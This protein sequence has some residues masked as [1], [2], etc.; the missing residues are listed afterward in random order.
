MMDEN[1]LLHRRRAL[2][3][4]E[5]MKDAGKSWELYVFSS[6]NAIRKYAMEELVELGISWVWMGLESPQSGYAKLD[7]AD[8]L[9]LVRELR[10][11]GIRVL[12][13]T[14]VGL[15]HH[16]PENIH[17]EIEHAC[18]HETDF[19]QFMLYTAMPGTPL[20]AQLSEE[21]RLLDD[22]EVADIHGQFKFNWRHP[23]ISRDESKTFLDDA[24]TRDFELNGPSIYRICRTTLEGLKRYRFHPDLRV[25]ERFEREAKA[26]R[27]QYSAVLWAMEKHL[28]ETNQAVAG[29]VAA[30]REEIRRECGALRS[31]ASAWAYGPLML[32][33][34]RREERRL[35][36]GV[37]YEPETFVERRNWVE[38]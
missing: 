22:V 18:A 19:H 1:F 15:E 35:A 30:L 21:G 23:Y 13:S 4:L 25:R 10:S 36:E 12:G 6:A 2:E 3:L 5:C 31:R 16:T 8:T 34:T 17:R 9:A 33:L 27:N 24:F 32:W 26:L 7:G 37:T 38:A 14:I 29:R 20:H 28:K 11:H